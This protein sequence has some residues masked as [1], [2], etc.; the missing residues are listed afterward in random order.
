MEIERSI[1]IMK[2][3]SDSSRLRLLNALMAKPQYVEEIANRLNLA[4]STIS[5]HL[6]KLEK[7]G[8]VSK[9]KEQYYITYTLTPEILNL[10]LRELTSFENIE[11]YAEEER[12]DKYRA[13]VLKSF[14]K[15]GRITRLPVQHKKKKILL[16]EIVKLF[17]TKI[18]FTEMEVDEIIH[19]IFDD[20]C[21]IRRLLI[22]EGIM[23]REG[24]NYWLTQH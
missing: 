4:V 20:H 21:T 12:L 22:D 5:F 14:M 11:Q 2:T 13:K 7:V 8:L 3:L 10:T 6:K 17:G 18:K 1:E 15:E 9:R 19:T 24:L 23:R 16:D